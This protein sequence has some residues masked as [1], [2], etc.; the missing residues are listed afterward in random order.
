M[1]LPTETRLN[2]VEN[3]ISHHHQSVTQ[4][5][6]PIN[7]TLKQILLY[8]QTTLAAV[9]VALLMPQHKTINKYAK[10]INQRW[11]AGFGCLFLLK[12]YYNPCLDLYTA[13]FSM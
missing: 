3:P 8:R 5:Q 13:D 2:I 11:V 9:A 12:K 7:H 4:S 1:R 10:T 6:E